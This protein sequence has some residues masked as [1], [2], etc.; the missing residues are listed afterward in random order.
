M[1]VVWF[2][3]GECRLELAGFPGR[4][5]VEQSEPFRVW[6]RAAMSRADGFVSAGVAVMVGGFVR[7]R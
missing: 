1:W 4:G 6:W 2:P 7:G 5:I 3:V